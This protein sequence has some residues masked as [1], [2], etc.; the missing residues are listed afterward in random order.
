MAFTIMLFSL[1]YYHILP[2]GPAVLGG[3]LTASRRG[4]LGLIPDQVIWD[5]W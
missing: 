5:L 2:L 1:L 4:G 3:Y